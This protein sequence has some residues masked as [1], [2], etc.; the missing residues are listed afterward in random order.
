M[1]KLSSELE[2]SNCEIC[3]LSSEVFTELINTNLEHI[4]LLLKE[5]NSYFKDLKIF[6]TTRDPTERALSQLK[7][8]IRR[9]NINTKLKI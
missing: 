3:F 7:A 2:V 4:N 6:I 8:M 9:S 5:L 1:E